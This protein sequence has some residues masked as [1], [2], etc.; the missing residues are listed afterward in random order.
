MAANTSKRSRSY[1]VERCEAADASE[2]VEDVDEADVA[3]GGRVQLAHVNLVAMPIDQLP[4]HVG[5]QSVAQGDPHGVVAVVFALP[6][7]RTR[8]ITRDF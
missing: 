5:P 2:L 4:P 7:T 6:G 3:L 8:L 1:L